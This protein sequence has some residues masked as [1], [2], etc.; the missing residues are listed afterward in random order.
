MTK[1][2]IEEFFQKMDAATSL[3]EARQLRDEFYRD[4][5]AFAD[6]D[7]AYL[8]QRLRERSEQ[9]IRALAETDAE[10]EKH[11]ARTQPVV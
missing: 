11:F 4:P 8:R 5:S 7:R 1:E 6:D 9:L 10:V 3:D 2:Q